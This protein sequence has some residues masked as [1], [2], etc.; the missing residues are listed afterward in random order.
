MGEDKLPTHRKAVNGVSADC[1]ALDLDHCFDGWPGVV[2]LR[3]PLLH[4][5]MSSN[6]DHLV[7]FTND[8]RDFVAIEPVSHVNNA[9]NLMHTLGSTAPA[10]GVRV[11]QAGASL[12]VA[13]R[14][15]VAVNGD[16]DGVEE[17]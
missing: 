5:Q 12:S 8:S 6:L 9:F 13:M 14:I 16:G 4:T 1:D 3:D 7:V 2:H 17:G 11:L 15:D 10:L